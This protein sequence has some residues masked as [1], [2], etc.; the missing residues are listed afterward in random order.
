MY[1][2]IFYMAQYV[3]CWIYFFLTGIKTV[4]II[5]FSRETGKFV[6]TTYETINCKW[7]IFFVICK[8]RALKTSQINI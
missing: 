2:N 8:K 5:L 3:L 6:S 7:E 4:Q 1:V